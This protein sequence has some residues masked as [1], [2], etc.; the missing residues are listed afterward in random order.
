MST[1]LVARRCGREQESAS[2]RPCGGSIDPRKAVS[3]VRVM[4]SDRHED[5]ADGTVTPRA[6]RLDDLD[7]AIIK[8]LQEDGRRSYREIGRDL[9]VPEGTIRFRAKRLTDSGALRIV[10]IADPF[11]LGYRVL[12][13][14]L[15]RIEPGQVQR[16]TDVLV[17]WREVTYVSSCTGEVD[18]YI[19]VVCRDHDELFELVSRRIPDIGGITRIETFM[20]L[21]MHKIAY[22]YGGPGG[23]PI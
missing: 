12:A 18:T 5:S 23:V 1:T 15:L 19:Q 16:V 6:L 4:P 7:R 8:H 9:G 20:E 22:D 10:A 3:L 11:R 14:I 2:N 21:K 13:F 17:S